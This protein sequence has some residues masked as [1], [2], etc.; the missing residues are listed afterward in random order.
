VVVVVCPYGSRAP[1]YEFLRDHPAALYVEKPFA[2]SVA[3]LERICRI[4]PD[5]ALAAG[6][7]RRSDGVTSIVKGLMEAQF[8]GEL[9][10]VRSEFGSATGISAG[11]GFAKNVSLAG[12]GQLFESAI[13]NI[14][15]IC[16][17]AGIERAFVKE[18]RMEAE[19]QFDL[20]TEA[21]I[22]LTSA[23]GRRIDME[24]LVTCFRNTQYQ[25]EM[26][27]DRALLTF[28]LF[29]RTP[30]KVRAFEGQ[31][32]FQILDAN[33]ADYPRGTFDSLHVFWADFLSGLEAR[34]PNYT[35]ARS[36]AATASII[37]QLYE[38]GVRTAP[39]GMLAH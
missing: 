2:R 9:R 1:Y 25:I 36:S 16:Y 24:L 33:L 22:E 4:R 15:T 30:P 28:S 13:H 14:D 23:S 12:G 18:C 27:F 7:L 38:L 8:F 34:Q 31:R 37:E 5:Y 3:E 39:S 32:T 26:E 19:G 29:K 20:E 6:F 35:S 17:V 10:C 21:H 11:A